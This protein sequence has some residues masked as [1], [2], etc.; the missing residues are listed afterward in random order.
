MKI[1]RNVV[2]YNQSSQSTRLRFNDIFVIETVTAISI[3]AGNVIVFFFQLLLKLMLVDFDTN[4]TSALFMNN[5][6]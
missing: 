4:F 3:C 6:I 2:Y 1:S 5:T